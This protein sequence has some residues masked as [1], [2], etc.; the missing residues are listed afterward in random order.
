MENP[1]YFLKIIYYGLNFY[2]FYFNFVDEMMNLYIFL[3]NF[4]FELLL[5]IQTWQLK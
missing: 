5:Y 4:A 2:F 1:K 3:S